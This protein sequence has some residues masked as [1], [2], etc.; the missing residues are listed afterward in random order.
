MSTNIAATET[1]NIEI[2]S[3][4]MP[5]QPIARAIICATHTKR[6]SQTQCCIDDSGLLVL[7]G[8]SILDSSTEIA[9]R[10]SATSVPN[11][12]L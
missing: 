3:R 7:L 9:T 4:F 12:A 11:A 10:S 8:N 6:P 5:F 2:D 1:C